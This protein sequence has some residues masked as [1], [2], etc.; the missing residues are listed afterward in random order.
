MAISY[1]DALNFP[2]LNAERKKAVDELERVCDGW[3]RTSF[4]AGDTKQQTFNPGLRDA[5]ERR[6]SG[7]IRLSPKNSCDCTVRLD[8]T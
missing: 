4:Y 5:T 3:L 1:D 7:W 6:S 2:R 8:G